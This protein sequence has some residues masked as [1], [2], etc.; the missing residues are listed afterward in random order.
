MKPQ[1]GLDKP[2]WLKE[3]TPDRLLDADVAA[4]KLGWKDVGPDPHGVQLM[5]VPPPS[6]DVPHDSAEGYTCRF[7]RQR[8]HPRAEFLK[9]PHFASFYDDTKAVLFAMVNL[10]FNYAI[11]YY[12][13]F[14]Q[15]KAIFELAADTTIRGQSVETEFSFTICE[16]AL[17]AF[18]A[19]RQNTTPQEV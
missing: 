7:L 4:E 3:P 13:E 12:A 9:V 2:F 17:E 5:G 11:V 1:T 18:R 19:H 16:A 15:H 14:D 6:W 10:K 8:N